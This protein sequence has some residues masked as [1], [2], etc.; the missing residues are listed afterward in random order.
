MWWLLP[1]VSIGAVNCN[2]MNHF[3][4]FSQ[5]IFHSFVISRVL[6]RIGEHDFSSDYDRARPENFNISLTVH[7]ELYNP[8]TLQND[9][10]VLKLARKVHFNGKF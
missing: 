8:R 7:H 10:A 2:E 1:I 3:A 5:L 4:L 9:L 6:V